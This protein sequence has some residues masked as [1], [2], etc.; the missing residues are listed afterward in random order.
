MLFPKRVSGT[1]S[2]NLNNFFNLNQGIIMGN[3]AVVSQ[4]FHLESPKQPGEIGVFRDKDA[5]MDY[6]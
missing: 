2:Q 4:K 3:T 5:G 6:T 1:I